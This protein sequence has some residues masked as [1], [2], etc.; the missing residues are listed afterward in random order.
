[1]HIACPQLF[2]KNPER[3]DLA[4]ETT[5]TTSST[6]D[7]ETGTPEERSMDSVAV[8]YINRQLMQSAQ[9]AAAV[10]TALLV[11]AHDEH[12]EAI[13][14]ALLVSLDSDAIPAKWA[15]LQR[16]DV[17]DSEAIQA[18]WA[19]LRPFF[20][21]ILIQAEIR[22]FE[23]H[24]DSKYPEGLLS[25]QASGPITEWRQNQPEREA[26]RHYTA[27]QIKALLEDRSSTNANMQDAW[28]QEEMQDK[29]TQALAERRLTS[30]C[31]C[32][33]CL[34]VHAQT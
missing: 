19:Q 6:S 22:N 7:V 29:I 25:E 14:T 27:T 18:K 9:P 15:Q 32:R 4:E 10:Y 23:Q 8:P 34:P 31:P 2:M 3:N 24:V 30:A 26:E 20:K 21:D 16:R 5:T 33:A 1:M 17:L 28:W 12:L 11:T 13:T